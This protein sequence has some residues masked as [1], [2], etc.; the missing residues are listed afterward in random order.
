MAASCGSGSLSGKS[1]SREDVADLLDRLNLTMD[2]GEVV[3]LSDD[4]E[5][6]D[7][8]RMKWAVIREVLSP[9][10]LHITTIRNA[11]R[12]AWGNPYGL[13]LR[14]VG[15]KAN[16]LFIVEFGSSDD[17]KRVLEGSSWMVGRHTVVLQEYDETLKPSD[18]SFAKMEMWVRIL[19]LPFG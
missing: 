12:L 14:S 1:D 2:E 11:M 10:A 4:E 18:V 19:N 17:K 13:K 7:A 9:S 5:G 3:T 16:N 8:S 6:E 15:D